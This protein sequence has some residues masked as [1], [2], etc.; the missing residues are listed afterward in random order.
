MATPIGTPIDPTEPTL[1]NKSFYVNV[2]GTLKLVTRALADLGGSSLDDV[3]SGS[4]DDEFFNL[5]SGADTALAGGGDD[6][7][8]GGSGNDKLYGEAGNDDLRGGSGNDQLFGGSGNDVLDGGADADTLAGGTGDDLYRM[9]GQLDTVVENAGEGTDTIYTNVKFTTLPANV[10]RLVADPASTT[11]GVVFTGNAAANTLIGSAF[12]DQLDGG[13][14]A[15]AMHGGAGDDHYRVDHVGD[16]VVEAL[17]AG[18]DAVTTTLAQYTLPA[19]VEQ[20]YLDTPAGVAAKGTGNDGNNKLVGGAGNDH[21]RGLGGADVMSGGGGEDLLE[22]GT[23]DDLYFVNSGGDGVLE[24]L[25]AGIDSVFASV[26]AYELPANVENLSFMV[27]VDAQGQLNGPIHFVGLGNAG[28]NQITGSFGHDRFHGGAGAD[29]LIG[30]AGNDLLFGG[31]QAD[32]LDGGAGDDTLVEEDDY[33]ALAGNFID[34][35]VGGTGNDTY[36]AGANDVVKEEPGGGYDT[37]HVHAT[38]YTLPENFEALS[39]TLDAVVTLRGNAADNKIWATAQGGQLNG[40][41]GNDQLYGGAGNNYLYGEG[42]DD[43]L[44]GGELM[45]QLYGGAGADVMTGGGGTDRFWIQA[46]SSTAQARDRITDFTPGSDRLVLFMD[47]KPA[48]PNLDMPQYVG[49]GAFIGGGVGSARC[50]PIAGGQ[51]VQVDADGNGSADL[52]IDLMG[53]AAPLA[54]SDFGL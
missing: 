24:Q 39:S 50:E 11:G 1:V 8:D 4:L 35:L 7:L 45:D 38:Q 6:L 42:G 9:I 17:N 37:M 40:G 14:G 28:P 49:T 25:D 19:N 20:L 46:G 5:G 22:G 13:A 16:V 41:D 27:S 30:D 53:V 31:L 15:D 3:R 51:Q 36:Y 32:Y 43:Q 21:L 26:A 54:A 12:G 48:T 23:G 29:T 2:N 18:N 33:F 52:F 34:T 47:A 44:M 10:E